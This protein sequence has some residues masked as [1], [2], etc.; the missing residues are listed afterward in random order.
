MNVFEKSS[1]IPVSAKELFDYHDRPGALERLL[2][3]WRDFEIIERSGGIR[4]GGW[5]KVRMHIGPF[6]RTVTA[7]HHDFI[8][9]KQFVDEQESGPFAGWKHTHRFLA[10][11]NNSS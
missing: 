1:S 11:T 4:D 3:P 5:V 7:L 9:G 6:S 2:P 8:D 10:E